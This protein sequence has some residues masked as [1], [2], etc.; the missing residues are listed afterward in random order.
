MSSPKLCHRGWGTL[1]AQVTGDSI[2]HGHGPLGSRGNEATSWPVP[3]DSH[4]SALYREEET[5]ALP[6]AAPQN[7]IVSQHP[8]ANLPLKALG[9]PARDQPLSRSH[10]KGWGQARTLFPADFCPAM[11]S[12]SR[13]LCRRWCQETT[14]SSPAGQWAAETTLSV[15]RRKVQETTRP[16]PHYLPF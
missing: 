4:A 2:R 9:S 13:R 5:A 15:L 8:L 10:G 12:C 14:A 11:P 7:G 6:E 16:I 3:K 1:W